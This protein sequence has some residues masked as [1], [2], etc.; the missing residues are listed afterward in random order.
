[1]ITV[2]QAHSRTDLDA[3]FAIRRKVFVEEQKVPADL[4]YDEFDDEGAIHYLAE[5]DGKNVGAARWIET[6]EGYK[7][8][9]FAVLAEARGKGVGS[10][11][12]IKVLEDIPADGKKIYLH[13]QESATGLYLK[14]GFVIEGERFEEAGIGHYKMSKK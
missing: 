14:H 9:R 13:S 5:T 7:L 11:L 12:L 4:E 10:A 8:Q 3:V 2:K 6:A 1:M